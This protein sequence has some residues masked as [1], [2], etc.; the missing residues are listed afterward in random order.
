MDLDD[1]WIAVGDIHAC[2]DQLQEVLEQ[3]S[4]FPDHHWVFLGDYIDRGPDAERV[5][6]ILR[7]LDA[8]FLL[9]NHE[10]ML[11]DRLT[12]TPKTLEAWLENSGLSPES[13]QWLAEVP[14]LVWETKDYIFVHGGLNV[15]KPLD[16]Q[17]RYD[18]LW[19]RHNGD[20]RTLTPKWVIHGHHSIDEPLIEG[21]RVNINTRCGSGGPLTAVV[22]PEFKFLQ[23]SASPV[24][25]SGL[26]L[27]PRDLAALIDD[28][29]EELPEEG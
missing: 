20:Y 13:A 15:A 2:P 8:V 26:I 29:L 6:T 16:N 12:S 25:R 18:F 24:P 28:T 21:N 11:L 4:R 23:S 1:R 27:S 14:R 5:V 9:G 17:T 19:T 7:G 3:A 10:Q 22:L